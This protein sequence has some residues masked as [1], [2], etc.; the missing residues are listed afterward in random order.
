MPKFAERLRTRWL[1][2][3]FSQKSN[4]D[5]REESSSV[6]VPADRNPAAVFWSGIADR[7][8]DAAFSV[9]ADDAKINIVPAGILG[10]TV[11]GRAFFANTVAAFPDVEF[12][13][14]KSFDGTNGVTVTELSMEG[15]QAGDY[16]GVVNQ[17][18]H[19][20]VDQVWLLVNRNGLISSI[21][22]YW[23]Q[24]QLYRR[25]AVKRLDQVAIVGGSTT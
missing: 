17:E 12:F 1:H 24:N 9:V 10:S 22:G 6:S 2:R 11:E 8:V 3:G 4:E 23:C 5:L 13:V 14:K 15:T 18:K 25:L 21:T 20:D 16:L 19:I 7:D